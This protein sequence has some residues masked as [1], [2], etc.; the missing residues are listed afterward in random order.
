[1]KGEIMDNKGIKRASI[2]LAGAVIS[3]LAATALFTGTVFAD[4]LQPYVVKNNDCLY[5]IARNTLGNGERWKEIYELNAGTIKDPSLIFPGQQL[6]LPGDGIPQVTAPTEE[7]PAI[8]DTASLQALL[9]TAALPADQAGNIDEESRADSLARDKYKR[10]G[11]AE[12]YVTAVLKS[13]ESDKAHLVGLDYRLKTVESLRRK[14]LSDSHDME[15]SL[16]EAAANINDS[17]RYTI[18]AD[19]AEYAD[20]TK[21]TLDTLSAMGMTVF[22]FK[23]YWA[24]DSRSYQGINVNLKTPEGV[25]FELQFHTPDS[26]DTKE[27]KT[28]TYY[29]IQRDENTTAEEKAEATR[30]MDEL[31]ALVPVPEGVRQL[32]YATAK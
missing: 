23:N 22:K 8:A 5:S 30:I 9:Q 26:Y 32:K 3:F 21:K 29:E 19:D 31:F 11:E 6:L 13:L 7:T 20:I 4:T 27:D 17:L 15:V 28:H 2:F 10:A 1:M 25:V 18:V 24:D 16:E 12:P 14:I